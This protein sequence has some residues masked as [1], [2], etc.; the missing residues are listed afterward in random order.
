MIKRPNVYRFQGGPEIR[1]GVRASLI[2]D[3]I[4][5]GLNCASETH[6]SVQADVLRLA[7]NQTVP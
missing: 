3:A 2:S 4:T 7:D 6:R 5:E 1:N